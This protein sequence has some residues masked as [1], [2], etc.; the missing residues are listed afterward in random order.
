MAVEVDPEDDPIPRETEQE[1]MRQLKLSFE[2]R[3]DRLSFDV[4]RISKGMETLFNRI[5]SQ[6]KASMDQYEE[7]ARD[8]DSFE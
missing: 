5:A 3:F 4:S 7:E 8:N 6:D 2:S 1:R